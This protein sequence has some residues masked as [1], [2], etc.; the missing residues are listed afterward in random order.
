MTHV[1]DKKPVKE[2]QLLW[3]M[4]LGQVLSKKESRATSRQLSYVKR[5]Q[6]IEIT[7][8]DLIAVDITA[9]VEWLYGVFDTSSNSRVVPTFEQKH[10]STF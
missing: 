1:R 7:R 3:L 2:Q 6:W 9:T 5:K 8:R 4:T 10:A